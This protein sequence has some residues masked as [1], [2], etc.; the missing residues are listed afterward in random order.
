MGSQPLFVFCGWCG[1]VRS[2][3]VALVGLG[4][5]ISLS[6][7]PSPMS[8][9][10]SP[11]PFTFTLSPFP[12]FSL[13]TL[14]PSPFLLFFFYPLPSPPHC[15]PYFTEGSTSQGKGG[16]PA[17]LRAFVSGSGLGWGWCGLG[18]DFQKMLDG[19]KVAQI[20]RGTEGFVVVIAPDGIGPLP[21]PPDFAGFAP[22]LPGPSPVSRTPP[23]PT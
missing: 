5:F 6:I 8:A 4:C 19:R 21:D 16:T 18:P 1:L 9:P 13:V 22:A 12:L 7:L 2:G 23:P 15:P 11:S 17:S 10:P 3:W 14:S 20:V